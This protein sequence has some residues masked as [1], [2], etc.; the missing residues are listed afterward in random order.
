MSSFCFGLRL[1]IGLLSIYNT[2]PDLLFISGW[3]IPLTNDEFKL[4][5]D[6]LDKTKTDSWNV[7]SIAALNPEEVVIKLPAVENPIGFP[8]VKTV[9]E[10]FWSYDRSL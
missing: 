3:E 2:S 9:F 5:D 6:V 8:W 10:S 1:T 7:G 4:I